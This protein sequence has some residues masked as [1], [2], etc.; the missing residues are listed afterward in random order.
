MSTDYGKVRNKFQC[1]AYQFVLVMLVAVVT[2]QAS[3]DYERIVLI[4]R[5]QT[6]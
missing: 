5:W 2:K 6:K 3:E 4:D 1:V